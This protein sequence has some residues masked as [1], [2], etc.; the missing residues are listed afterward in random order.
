[1][2]KV[3]L[4]GLLK[5]I[6][7]RHGFTL[8]AVKVYDGVHLH[9]F[10]SA[11]SRISILEMVGVLKCV[12]AKV[13]FVEFPELTEQLWEGHLWSESYAVRAAGNVTSVKIE[14]YIN[15]S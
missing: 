11:S 6:A 9:L 15:N 10:V 12:T 7:E 3:R 8:L 13:L 5:E 1:M 4:E 14:E 2:V